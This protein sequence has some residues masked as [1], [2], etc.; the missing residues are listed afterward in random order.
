LSEIAV[1]QDKIIYKG[2]IYAMVP[3]ITASVVMLIDKKRRKKN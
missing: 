1:L 2:K 3:T